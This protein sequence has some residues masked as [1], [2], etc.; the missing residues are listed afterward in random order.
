MDHYL[1]NLLGMFQ[2]DP[3]V[4]FRVMLNNV[5]LD[6]RNFTP[7]PKYYLVWVEIKRLNC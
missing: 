4:G 6:G 5:R 3:T 1:W 2:L 7:K